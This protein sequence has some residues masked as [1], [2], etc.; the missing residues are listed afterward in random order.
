MAVGWAGATNEKRWL[1]ALSAVLVAYQIAYV[2]YYLARLLSVLDI[3]RRQAI[4]VPITQIM[5]YIRCV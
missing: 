2:T 5:S 4:S 1:M 3:S